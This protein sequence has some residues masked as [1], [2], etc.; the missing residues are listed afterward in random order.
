VACYPFPSEVFDL[1]HVPLVFEYVDWERLLPAL[2]GSLRLRGILSVVVQRPSPSAPAVSLS[3]YPSLQKLARLFRFV[4]LDTLRALA[5]GEGLRIES[6]FEIL[7][8]V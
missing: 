1:I 2:V 6:E 3:Q 4:R 7:G 8:R 5:V